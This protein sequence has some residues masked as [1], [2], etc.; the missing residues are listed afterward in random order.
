MLFCKG[1]F[2]SSHHTRSLEENRKIARRLLQ[3]KLDYHY[4]KEESYL[5]KQQA[6]KTEEKRE[7][8]IKAQ[9]RLKRKLEFKDREGLD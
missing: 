5:S 8:K 2:V 7:K 3:E 9:Q 6:K 4:N 1:I